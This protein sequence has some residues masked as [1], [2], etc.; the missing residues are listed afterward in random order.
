MLLTLFNSIVHL[1][2]AF[3]VKIMTSM[4]FTLVFQVIACKDI[5]SVD[6]RQILKFVIP[7]LAWLSV[8]GQKP[9]RFHSSYFKGI[10]HPKMKILSPSCR[11][12]P[13]RPSIIF[14]IQ[15]KIFLM[16]SESFLTLHRQQGN[17]NVP[18]PRNDIIKISTLPSGGAAEFSRL[19]ISSAQNCAFMCVSLP[20]FLFFYFSF[21]TCIVCNDYVRQKNTFGHWTTLH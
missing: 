7:Q 5:G 10:I 4:Y 13:T 9:L 11:S 6:L 19:W 15:I 21:D 1:Y 16:K 8:K 2:L 12:K 17:W 3:T 20:I 18:R 14:G